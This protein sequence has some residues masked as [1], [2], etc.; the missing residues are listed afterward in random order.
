MRRFCDGT[1]K[2][3]HC[4]TLRQQAVT[5]GS[6]ESCRTDPA[7]RPLSPENVMQATLAVHLDV[8]WFRT[9]YHAVVVRPGEWPA[10]E[11]NDVCY[12]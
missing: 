9:G 10:G 4:V 5:T 12:P 6:P 2:V 3:T 7:L 1:A 8:G 11:K